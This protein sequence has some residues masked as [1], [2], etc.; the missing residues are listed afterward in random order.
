MLSMTRRA[1]LGSL[2]TAMGA[3]A[4]TALPGCSIGN[5]GVTGTWYGIDEDGHTSTLEIN[6]DGTWL[7]NG[8]YTASGD[9]NE[10]DSGTI[11]LTAPLVSIPYTLEGDGDDRALVFAGEDPS[12]GNAPEISESTFYATEAARDSAMKE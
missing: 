12:S 6:E 7:F 9:W 5:Q 10:T 11:V 4:L 8:K 3:V 2:L 1:F